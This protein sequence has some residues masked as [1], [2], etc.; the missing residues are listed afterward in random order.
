MLNK[1]IFL[2]SC[3]NFNVEGGNVSFHCPKGYLLQGAPGS[4]CSHTGKTVPLRWEYE[5]PLSEGLPAAG[6]LLLPYRY[7]GL[8]INKR[9]INEGRSYLL[10]LDNKKKI[11]GGGEGKYPWQGTQ[12]AQHQHR[13]KVG[14]GCNPMHL[15]ACS[16][17]FLCNKLQ[18]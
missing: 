17:S 11:F 7:K 13:Q 3:I 2:L 10:H 16:K 14:W 5:L 9:K 1:H 18:L 8:F 12:I 4:Y 15:P 6:Q